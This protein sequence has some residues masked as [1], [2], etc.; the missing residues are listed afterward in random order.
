MEHKI[1]I[2]ERDQVVAAALARLIA[3]EKLDDCCAV[4]APEFAPPAVETMTLGPPPVRAGALLEKIQAALAASRAQDDHVAFGGH[5]INARA[6]HFTRAD[7]AVF[8]LTEK[9]TGI[10]MMLA[11]AK[12]AAVDRK[13]ILDAVWGYAE[14]VETH[15]L[16]THIYRLRQKIEAAPADP[17]ILLTDDA[18][19]KI[20][21]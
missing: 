19:Y 7:G 3:A 18:G 20:G 12:G 9:E 5:T 1:L 2:L 21:T 16:E 6:M 8:K 10:L 15:T 13:S 11:R 14:T 17:V 4:V